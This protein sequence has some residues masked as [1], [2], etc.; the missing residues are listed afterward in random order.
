MQPRNQECKV[1]LQR[2]AGAAWLIRTKRL[3]EQMVDPAGPAASTGYLR[4]H[5]GAGRGSLAWLVRTPKIDMIEMFL[6]GGNEDTKLI[7]VISIS[8]LLWLSAKV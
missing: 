5:E 4:W 7:L 8:A 2:P 6:V 3:V 1:E